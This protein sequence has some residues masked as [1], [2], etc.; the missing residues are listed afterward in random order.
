MKSVINSIYTSNLVKTTSNN[1]KI[2]G[3]KKNTQL[4]TICEWP[5]TVKNKGRTLNTEITE[6]GSTRLLKPVGLFKV[7]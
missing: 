1:P 7:T 4:F 2:K 5:N 3:E 6:V